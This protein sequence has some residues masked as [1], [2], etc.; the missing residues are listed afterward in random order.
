ME[1]AKKISTAVLE[2]YQDRLVAKNIAWS[3]KFDIGELRAYVVARVVTK[4]DS[5]DRVLRKL[6]KQN[7]LNYVVLNR[8][9]SIYQVLPLPQGNS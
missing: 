1:Q 2:F 8:N 5:V 3:G 6:R 7:K 9:A 4:E